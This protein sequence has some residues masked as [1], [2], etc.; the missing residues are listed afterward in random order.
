MFFRAI[1]LLITVRILPI[2]FNSLLYA[3]IL[4]LYL[5]IVYLYYLNY[6]VLSF[7]NVALSNLID[8]GFVNVIN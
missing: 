3:R 6:L 1:V 5:I 7:I 8:S 2:S 4:A